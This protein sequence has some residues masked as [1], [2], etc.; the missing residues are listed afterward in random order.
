MSLLEYAKQAQA[1]AAQAAKESRVAVSLYEE[2]CKTHFGLDA[3]V[4]SD[5]AS[6]I[7]Q[8]ENVINSS[9]TNSDGSFTGVAAVASGLVGDLPTGALKSFASQIVEIGESAAAGAAIGSCFPGFGTAIGA[10]VG[11]VIGFVED[12]FSSPPPVPEGE[13]RQPWEK[14]VFPAV[15]NTATNDTNPDNLLAQKVVSPASWADIRTHSVGFQVPFQGTD[16]ATGQTVIADFNFAVDWVPP[17]G[18]NKQSSGA[19]FYVAQAWIGQNAVSLAVISKSNNSQ[20]LKD[21]ANI[22]YQ[23]AITVLG[24][25]EAVTRAIT[26]LDS[27][28]GQ[29]FPLTW[30]V[31]DGGIS[32]ISSD[33][34]VIAQ[35]EAF[36]KQV[37]E[38]QPLDYTYYWSP[39]VV[40]TPNSQTP[41]APLVDVFHIGAAMAGAVRY[42][43]MPDTS[44]IG[45]AELACLVQLGIIPANGADFVALHYMMSLAWLWRRGQIESQSSG[46]PQA[47]YNHPNFSRIIG[48]VATRVHQSK[49]KISPGV[50]TSGA[51]SVMLG[52]GN[53]G[54]TSFSGRSRNSWKWFLGLVAGV[55]SIAW[56][57]SRKE[58]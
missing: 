39:E 49:N 8:G 15:P 30:T 24:S 55:G 33:P 48:I 51:K 25:S 29:S 44:I 9:F 5:P 31:G 53:Q 32:D 36:A 10:A 21:A 17:P 54:S 35:A 34:H 57:S 23:K 52:S 12:L 40:Y 58:K 2:A 4:I 46:N 3:H 47:I 19:A 50:L 22:A 37:S 13:F 41:V 18:S 43:A 14:Y 6:A 42:V 28:Y 1:R 27:W 56:I 45:L 7:S 16:P 38:T 26:I 20:A 11:A